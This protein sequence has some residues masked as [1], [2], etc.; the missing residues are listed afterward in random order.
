[1]FSLIDVGKPLAVGRGMAFFNLRSSGKQNGWL[2][3]VLIG[4][5]VATAAYGIWLFNTQ[6]GVG[7]YRDDA[8]YVSTARAIAEG[9]GPRLEYLPGA[10]YAT[11]YP[12]L[13]PALLA[14]VLEFTGSSD[15]ETT[16]PV[17]VA[18]NAL[19]LPLALLAYAAI[20]HRSWRFPPLVTLLLLLCLGFNPLILEFSRFPL[21]EILYIALSISALAF[22]DASGHRPSRKS[23]AVAAIL[24]VAALHTRMIGATIVVAL[25]L[26]FA[27][28]RR[29]FAFLLTGA[30]A[31]VT[32]TAWIGFL[33]YA[34]SVDAGL[35]A[36]PLLAYDLGYAGYSTGGV[37]RLASAMVNVP[38]VAFF[39]ATIGLGVSLPS[40]LMARAIGGESALQLIAM[41]L[42]FLALLFAG[43][44]A[45]LACRAPLPAFARAETWYVP[46]YLA[47]ILSWPSSTARLLVPLA[48]WFL[49]LPVKAVASL[50][51][52]HLSRL[53]PIVCSAILLTLTLTALPR[54]QAPTP[55]HFMAA[56]MPIDTRELEGA[57]EAVRALPPGAQVGSPMAP[58]VFLHT[59]RRGVGHWVAQGVEGPSTKGRD[60]RTFFVGSREVDVTKVYQSIK[61]ALAE[62]PHLG[63]GYA[64][65]RRLQLPDLFGAAVAALPGTRL[66]YRSRGYE[67]YALPNSAANREGL[68][69][70]KSPPA[71]TS[72]RRAPG[73]GRG[74]RAILFSRFW[75]R[76]VSRAL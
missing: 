67:L 26:A 10:P 22:A 52:R 64:L 13:W 70:K 73:P 65:T 55:H 30:L 47:I 46:L 51:S 53:A 66:L 35:H 32:I 18:P 31:L 54:N 29:W 34:A 48:P 76:G 74:I 5:A 36:S 33:R 6:L 43:L 15:S 62:Y 20:L 69:P 61:D 19:L 14:A 72:S 21:S 11:K 37:G 50:P 9:R 24:A 40:K 38:R 45:R 68:Q 28:R 58:L 8:A 3:L 71:P 25:L 75:R 41:V 56:G 39:S 57:L 27:L 12:L 63:V 17:V 49:A 23:E 4:I 2:I 59:G 60:L 1:M 44:R 16:G 7:W 42:G